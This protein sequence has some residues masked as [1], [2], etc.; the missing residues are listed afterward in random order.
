MRQRPNC[1]GVDTDRVEEVLVS[2]TF[3]ASVPVLRESATQ[4]DVYESLCEEVVELAGST[5]DASGIIINYGE[6]GSGKNHTMLG[7]QGVLETALAELFRLKTIEDKATNDPAQPVM[8]LQVSIFEVAGNTILD[9]INRKQVESLS[10]VGNLDGLCAHPLASLD[11]TK[12]LF[13]VVLKGRKTAMTDL[14]EHSRTHLFINLQFTRTNQNSSTL[15]LVD[16]AGSEKSQ[17]GLNKQRDR[18]GALIN[19]SLLALGKCFRAITSGT[20][21]PWNESSLTKILKCYLARLDATHRIA[22]VACI[23]PE[24]DT[25]RS[26][27]PSRS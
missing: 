2:P 12:K 24:T 22:L 14:N 6:Y 13:Q 5:E 8:T 25:R 10:K 11:Y 1:G 9:L 27:W 18:E 20:K 7:E 3:T 23:Q 17:R 26:P 15:T 4:R 16:L 21:P 19:T